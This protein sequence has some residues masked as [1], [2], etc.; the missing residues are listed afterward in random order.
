MNP[1]LA[2]DLEDRDDVR[3]IE[4]RGG[5]PLDPEPLDL[6][7]IRRGGD[8]KHL[9]GDLPAGRD[10]HGLVDHAHPTA[11]DLADDPVAADR[12]RVET[13]I[14][15]PAASDRSNERR[16]LAIVAAA[17]SSSSNASVCFGCSAANARASTRSPAWNRSMNWSTN[18]A[19]MMSDSA[20][21]VVLVTPLRI[22]A[23]PRGKFGRAGARGC[24]EPWRRP[25]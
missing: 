5:L 11:A 25:R 15:G 9:E 2:A 10:L 19:R 23:V 24:V 21:R 16:S 17:G 1:L 6:P 12:V 14:G 3:V 8:R 22:I 7:G 13:E 4:R 20:S 18:S